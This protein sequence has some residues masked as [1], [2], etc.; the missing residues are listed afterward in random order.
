MSLRYEKH[1]ISEIADKPFLTKKWGYI[2]ALALLP[3]AFLKSLWA[4]GLTAGLT[5]KQAIQ[6]VAGFGDTLKEGPAFLY[7]L[8]TN[9]IDFTAILA[10]LASLF[11]LALV[12]S[13][14]EKLPKWLLIISGWSVGIVTVLISFM[15][16]LQF[17]GVFPKGYS[18][19]LAIWVYV[20]TYGGLF[21]WGITIFIATL[22]FQHRIKSKQSS[23]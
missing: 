9:G 6:D 5:T 3:Y 4:S 10:I 8:Y 1:R 19:G 14:G 17:F 12:T 22:S 15:T 2:A 7:T 11:A 21:L 13:W 23:K 18:E 20:V 16:A